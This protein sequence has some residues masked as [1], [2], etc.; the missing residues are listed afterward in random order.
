[1]RAPLLA[2]A[3][4]AA[5]LLIWWARPAA[6]ATPPPSAQPAPAPSALAWPVPA[7]A[8]SAAPVPGPFSALGQAERLQRRE[9]VQQRL[10]RAEE[11]LAA[12]RQ[13]AR[14]P[15]GTRPAREQPDQL[16][17]FAPIAEEHPLRTPG[18]TAS[19]G[20]KLLTQ[21]ERVF[22]SG[23]E[24]CRVSLRL[25]DAEGNALPL[26][27]TRAVF[28]EVS[29]PG[30][31]AQTAERA[32]SLQADGQGGFATVLAPAQQGFAGFAGRLRLELWMQYGGQPG[33]TYFDLIYTPGEAARWRGGVAETLVD[34]HLRFSLPVEVLQAGRYVASLRVD[35]AAGQ[36][37]AVLLFNEELGA[38]TRS[39]VFT[40]HGRLLHDLKPA[41]PLRL[42]DVEAFLL[43][44][45]RF[46]D[47]W[48]L[49]RLVGEQHRSQSYALERFS[50][51]EWQSE[52]KRRYLGELGKDVDE[53]RAELKRLGGP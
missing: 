6:E 13:H 5:A 28:K 51:A 37:L 8:A 4:A 43:V 2:V 29:E 39:I 10:E 44:P 46:P 20:V 34:G 42:R 38:G 52:E 14:Y 41:M 36:P 40:L 30:R 31:T 33:F 35:D 15:H 1:M 48:M 47:R 18:G 16:R 17:P 27:I 11:A 9:A 22:L 45:D 26:S 21:Q 12:Y 24:T 23:P 32:L 50:S 7:R 49:P 3:A 19:Q 25:V 53:A